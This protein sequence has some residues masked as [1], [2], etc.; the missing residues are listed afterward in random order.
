MEDRKF[1]N[2]EEAFNN[3]KKHLISF[4]LGNSLN[5]DLTEGK[6]GLVPN[7]DYFNR[8][9][10]SGRWNFLT[11]RSMAIGQ[12]ELGVTPL[13]MAN[14]TASISNRGYFY[15]PH[16]LKSVAGGQ[17][18]DRKFSEK[19]K[20]D[21]DSVNF[22]II[23][24]GMFL[25]VN[26]G[27]GSTASRA[28]IPDIEVCGKTGTAENPFGEDHSIFIAFAP[29]VNPKIAIAVYIENGGFGGTWAAPLAR[30]MIEKYIKRE[31][32]RP[33]LEIYLYNGKTT[34]LL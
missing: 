28:I 18:I 8:Y 4:G 24:D 10:G 25:A 31:I 7:A 34:P 5:S 20:I 13:Q 32:T 15:T 14:M 21:I 33:D 16:I 9:Y 12:G 17:Q 3:W 29:K 23:V 22:E 26:G 11:I 27:P 30:L 6:T 2:T 1:E 19:H